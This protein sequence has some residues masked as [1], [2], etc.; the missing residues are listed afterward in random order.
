MTDDDTHPPLTIATPDTPGHLFTVSEAARACRVDRRTL[1][2]L[3][4]KGEFPNARRTV[5]PRGP[6]TGPWEIPYRDLTAAGLKVNQGAGP[7][8]PTTTVVDLDVVARLRDENAEL[9]RRAEVAEARADER[10]R[11]IEVQAVA[12]R[13]LTAGPIVSGPAVDSEAHA[14]PS[15]PPPPTSAPQR[16]RLFHFRKP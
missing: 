10:E 12:L 8:V 1:K 2:R 16:R 9:R 3:L 7:D 5:G 4:D 13:A 11:V 15:P 6:D 14:T